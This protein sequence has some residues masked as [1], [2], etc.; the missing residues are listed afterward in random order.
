MHALLTLLLLLFSSPAIDAYLSS[1]TTNPLLLISR[2]TAALSFGLPNFDYVGKPKKGGEDRSEEEEQPK[3][4]LKSLIALVATGAGSPFLGDFEGVDEDT[5]TL[6][7]SLEANN[8][9]DEEGNSK[10][11]AMPFFEEGWVDEEEI[12]RKKAR[13]G[14]WPWEK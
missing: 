8:L 9:V 7:F 10:Q 1:T 13:K 5:G 14:K 12:A 6:N 2:R 3:M 11:T 4:S